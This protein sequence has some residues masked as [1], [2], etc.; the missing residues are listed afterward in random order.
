[1]EELKDI[2]GYEGFYK[3]SNYGR[4]F[5]IKRNRFLKPQIGIKNK[6]LYIILSKDKKGKGF[7]VHRLVAIA[8][9]PN[10]ENKEQV[11]HIDGNRSNNYLENLE[12]NTRSENNIHS[13][14]FLNRKAEN[15]HLIGMFG[16]LNHA[17][18][19]IF[20]YDRNNIFIKEYNSL[21]EASRE[22][23]VDHKN[24]CSVAR[25]KL[26]TA[27]GFIWRYEKI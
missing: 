20:Q 5:S 26:K 8:F 25:G 10:P 22:N 3:V 19:H 6:Y 12:W 27:G 9:I 23:N 21:I 4:I 15:K 1:M 17:S 16:G 11:N 2:I 7:L 24:L 14:K 13:F 18:R